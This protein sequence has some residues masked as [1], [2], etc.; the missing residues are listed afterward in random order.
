MSLDGL[1][2]DPAGDCI[3]STSDSAEV[4]AI[5]AVIRD[6]AQLHH[7]GGSSTQY[8]AQLRPDHAS[9]VLTKVFA[10]SG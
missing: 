1:C 6:P 2:G 8:K 3:S 10:H 4:S 7:V 9:L 5:V